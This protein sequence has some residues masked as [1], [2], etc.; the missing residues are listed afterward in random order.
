MEPT[1]GTLAETL[2][3]AADEAGRL[4]AFIDDLDG[5]DGQD[6]DTGSNAALTLDALAR[7]VGELEPADSFESALEV[8]VDAAVRSGVGHVGVL[9]G[10]VLATWA[11]ALGGAQSLRPVDVARM[12][13]ANPWECEGVHMDWSLAL[14]SMFDEGTSELET[15]GDT[16]PDVGGL[17]AVF[18]AQAQYGLVNATNDSTGRVDAG[19]AVLALLL[20]SLDAT[21]RSD[22]SMLD[23]LV[24]MLADL[25]GS[26]GAAS[27]RP[28]V[29]APGRAFTVDIVLHGTSEDAASARHALAGLGVRHSVV[30]RADLFGVG[31]WRLHVDTSA[32]LAVRPRSGTV[33]RFQVC[34]AR[35]DELIGQDMLSDGVTH[36]GVRLLERRTLARVE[37]AMVVACTRAPGLVEDLAQAG[38]V[39]LLDPD[40]QDTQALVQA[41]RASTT[42]VCLVAPCDPASVDL[43]RSVARHLEL[44]PTT[45]EGGGAGTAGADPATTRE[46]VPLRVLVADS[47]DDLSALQVAQACGTFFV[48]RPGGPGAAGVMEPMLRESAHRALARSLVA[49]LAVDAQ[50]GDLSAALQEI[51]ALPPRRLRLLVSRADG[52]VLVATLRQM[53]QGID[54]WTPAPDL[55]VIDGG[56]EGPSLLQGVR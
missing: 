56:Q 38:A 11:Q 19:A 49:T 34:D 32:P 50:G 14:E 29:P 6:C 13:R 12:L 8:G 25:A 37:R 27:P 26:P 44:P 43:A 33:V 53:N 39:T 48:P 28:Q 40:P 55:E 21:V 20:A 46:G 47:C 41:A 15:L 30:G 36:R 17:V 2:R 52:P 1:A 10:A 4:R 35:P 24:H 42:G 18:S 31:E 3:T 54:P 7:A 45:D 16:L 9:L 5:W 23:S 22:H 51:S